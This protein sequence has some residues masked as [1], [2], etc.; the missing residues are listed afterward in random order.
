MHK[1]KSAESAEKQRISGICE[2]YKRQKILVDIEDD[3]G[4]L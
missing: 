3:E 1:L 4:F 2:G